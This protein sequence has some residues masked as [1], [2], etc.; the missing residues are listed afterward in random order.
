MPLDPQ[1]QVVLEKMK[2]LDVPPLQALSVEDA[3]KVNLSPM[4]APPEEV[5]RVENRNI[6]GPAGSIPVRIYSPRSEAPLPVI[7]YYHGGGWVVGD[8]DA[9]DVLCRQLANGTGSIVVSVDYRLA[10]EHKFPAAAEDAYAAAEWVARNAGALGADP[11][12]VAVGG[13]SA[14]GNLAAVV[15]LMA[16][17]KGR[18]FIKFQLLVNP[19]ARHSFETDSY[20]ENA[21][22]YG[23][24]ADAMRWFWGHYLENEQDGLNPYASPLLA[25]D[26][27]GLPPALVL[28]AEFDPLRDEGEDYAKRLR[29]AGVPVESKRYDGMVHGFLLQTGGYDQG[30]KAL[31]HAVRALRDALRPA[32]A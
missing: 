19:V 6:P 21:E 1:V 4:A 11:E 3:R 13:D 20:R 23:L 29:D 14:G 30:R 10:P 5:W 16:R 31:E 9:A 27:S 25:A 2:Q 8:L 7:V 32:R 17:D 12:R 26:L 28:T 18:S 15:S 22:G 24:T